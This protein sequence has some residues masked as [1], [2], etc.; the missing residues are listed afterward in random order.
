M[1]CVR[2]INASARR[3]YDKAPVVD[4]QKLAQLVA[5]ATDLNE[6][7]EVRDEPSN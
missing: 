6:N 4:L 3:R 2:L 5:T 7:P 1:H